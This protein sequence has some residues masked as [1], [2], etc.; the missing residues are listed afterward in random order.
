MHLGLKRPECREF[1]SPPLPKVQFEAQLYRLPD[2]QPA[3]AD[4]QLAAAA[5]TGA[6]NTI[7][8]NFSLFLMVAKPVTGQRP[9]PDH[10]CEEVRR[11]QQVQHELPGTRRNGI[12]LSRARTEFQV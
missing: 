6:S 2:R 4:L 11:N 1:Q 5:A 8:Y 3:S 7:S 9:S 12:H 10:L